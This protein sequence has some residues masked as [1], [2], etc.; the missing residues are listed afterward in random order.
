MIKGIGHLKHGKTDGTEELYSDHL[1]NGCDS[2]DV[3]LTVIF[4]AMLIHGISPESMHL[5]TMVPIPKNKRQSLCIS[6][7]YRAIALSII[8]V[9]IPDWLILIK[10]EQSLSSSSLQFGFKGG[11]STTRSTF[12]L[13]ETVSYYNYNYTNVY[14]VFL[15]ASKAFDHVQYCKLFNELVNCNISPLVLRLLL[16]MYTKQKLQVRWG[17]TMSQQFTVRNGVMQGGVLSPILFAVYIDGLFSSL[18]ESGIGCHMGNSN[19]GGMGYADDIKLLCPSLKGMP[20][21]V[22]MCVDYAHEYNIKFNGSK[23]LMLLFKCR[24]C[25]GVTMHC[26]ESVSDLSHNVSTNDKDSIA[27]SAKASFWRSFNLFRSDLGHIYSFIKCK[28]F[29]QYCYSFYSAPLWS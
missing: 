16:N 8:L 27:K 2:L 3:Y 19:V 28:L 15:D 21:M 14:A 1:I 13:N 5:G 25:K 11:T 12:M 18:K 9:K 22:D 24:H 20:K 10:E 26:S 7:N 4:N 29:Q 17:N 6:D 23:S